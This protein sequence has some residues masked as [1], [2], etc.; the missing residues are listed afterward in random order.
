MRRFIITLACVTI[1]VSATLLFLN[2]KTEK[3]LLKTLNETK[4]YPKEAE[5]TS[6]EGK[7]EQTSHKGKQPNR[8]DSATN[9]TKR[10]SSFL[11]CID[12]GHQAN[13]NLEQEPIGP[14][15]AE[16]K[17]KVT[18][19]TTGV[20]TGKPEYVLN[21]EAAVILKELL[22]KKGIQVVMTRTSHDVD[23]S[24][25]ERAEMA[26]QNKAD[27]FIRIHAD[28]AENQDTRGFSVLV[29][30][31]NNPYTAKIYEDSFQAGQM[32]VHRVSEKN[33]TLLGNGL[34]PRED[35]SGFNWSRVPVILLE[36]G[37]MTNPEED[38]LL[39]NEKYLSDLLLQVAAGVADYASH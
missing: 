39:S 24:N 35:L 7:A 30:G 13:A 27:L 28:G 8:V 32:I 26:N 5:N 18:Y 19:G 38:L 23:I 22:E 21:L 1:L 17:N 33:Y 9:E 3:G 34:F 16:T 36:L 14:G 20:T 2:A 25:R 11:V 31:Q 29:P 4:Q 12:P 37:F 10:K 6:E 15:A